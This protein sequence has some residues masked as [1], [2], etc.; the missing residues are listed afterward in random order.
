[1]ECE[2]KILDILQGSEKWKRYRSRG[3]GA[4]DTAAILGISPYCTARQLYN[5]KKGLEP[6]QHVNAS[7]MRGNELEPIARQEAISKWGFQLTA[8]VVQSDE[9]PYLF[10]SL[11]GINEE[12]RTIIEIKCSDKIYEA[13]QKGII[14]EI[15][16]CQVQTQMLVTGYQ[17]VKFFA[18]DGFSCCLI[19]VKR[20]EAYIER[21][22]AACAEWWKYFERDEMPPLSGNDYESVEM[23]HE[24]FSA[25]NQWIIAKRELKAA[26]AIEKQWRDIITGWGKDGNCI[27]MY[28]DKPCVRMISVQRE[29]KVDWNSY[30]MAKEIT[31]SELEP[32]RKESCGYFQLREVK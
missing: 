16:M 12:T 4:T 30:C 5:R 9:I 3:I 31:N 22:K 23:D 14:D 28:K 6:E 1:M 13:A 24:Q 11:D 15:Y 8:C 29:A 7:M 32:F 17:T 18:F 2:M 20:D 25:V 19:E 21:I 27:L 10:A 26:E